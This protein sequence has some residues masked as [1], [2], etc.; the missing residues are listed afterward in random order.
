MVVVEVTRRRP[1]AT[2]RDLTDRCRQQEGAAAVLAGST[3]DGRAFL[4]FNLDQSLADTRH[5]CGRARPRRGEAHPG[6][7][8]R[9]ADARRGGRQEAGGARRGARSRARRRSSRSFE[10]P[11]AR[12]RFGPHGRGRLRSD[13]HPG[14]AALHGRAGRVGRR[15][16]PSPGARPGRAGRARRRRAAADAARRGRRSGR[17]DEPV[18]RAAPR[19]SWT[20]PS[21]RSTSASRP[22]SPVRARGRTPA[23]PRTSCRATSSGRGAGS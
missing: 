11:R 16:G 6:R 22:P 3:D 5:R 1:A 14:P 2:L 7:R 23:P 12:L 4:V 20:S 18:R 21:R 13:R 15:A 9:A 10:G 19:R 17:G 8:R